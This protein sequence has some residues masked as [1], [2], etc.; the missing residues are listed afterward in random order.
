MP[1]RRVP[2]L[3]DAQRQAWVR[4]T[5]GW[6]LIVLSVVFLM[7]YL[8]KNLYLD[9]PGDL[10]FSRLGKDLRGFIDPLLRDWRILDL[11]WR[12]MPPSQRRPALPTAPQ[13]EYLYVLWGAL[14]VAS[15]GGLLL[16]SA[17]IRWAQIKEFRWDMQREAWRQQV[18]T[19]QGLAP[20]DRGSTTVVAQGVWHQYM[21]PPESWSQTI[22]GVLIL[23]LIS[24]GGGGL[25]V[26]FI[27]LFAEYEYFQA[28]WPSSRN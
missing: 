13:W 10:F 1:K 21:A 19:A 6:L 16:R 2:T 28:R 14:V 8:V 15:I 12:A 9:L 25:I 23:G 4:A 22:W 7:L 26:A 18:R 20:D 17:Y 11:L 24:A 27:Q 3:A 5:I